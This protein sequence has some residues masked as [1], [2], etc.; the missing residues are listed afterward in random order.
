[1]L[2]LVFPAG[3]GYLL[4][5]LLGTVPLFLLLGLALGFAA[6]LYYVYLALKRMD[7]H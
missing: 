6:G 5:G 3:L 4:D 2:A 1:M 7:D